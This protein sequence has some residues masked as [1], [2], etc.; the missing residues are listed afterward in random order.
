[1]WVKDKWKI[2]KCFKIRYHHRKKK[3]KKKKR[4][5]TLTAFE[6]SNVVCRKNKKMTNKAESVSA[7]EIRN[8]V[9]I[10]STYLYHIRKI[11]IEDF[12]SPLSRH[13]RLTSQN[14]IMNRNCEVA[15][16]C[17]RSEALYLMR[18]CCYCLADE[19]HYNMH[20]WHTTCWLFSLSVVEFFLI[21][22]AK[23][24][25]TIFNFYSKN[26]LKNLFIFYMWVNK[27]IWQKKT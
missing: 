3:K 16:E 7:L 10:K 5:L 9:N 23:F 15:S 8:T 2:W 21:S 22:W 14:W 17:L 27:I 25:F 13:R 19:N 6:M 1:M 12:F 11:K 26:F 24:F 18:F 4:I 20:L